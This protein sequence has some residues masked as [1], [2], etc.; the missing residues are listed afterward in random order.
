MKSGRPRIQLKFASATTALTALLLSMPAHAVDG[1]KFLLCIAGPWS[2][3]PQCV[4][5]VR[6]VFRDLARGR[7]FPTCA[8]SGG[9][10]YAN[11]TWVNEAECPSMYRN[12]SHYANEYRGCRYP[13]RISV[14]VN[15]SLWSR[16][17]WNMR[18]TTTT[19]YSDAARTS[20]SRPQ[21]ALPLD[22]TFVSDL[23]RWNA[24]H[25]T[26]CQN[27]DGTPDLDG[28]GAFQKCNL[29]SWGYG[30]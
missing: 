17:F 21:N 14:F 18:G 1:C 15:G 13:G 5:I 9:G 7:P 8:M 25:V 12:Y 3:I 16:V 4:P 24:L 11:N 19:W 30:G 20:L 29:P 10:N 23:T 2:S 28:F 27:L 26:N 6:E 22:N